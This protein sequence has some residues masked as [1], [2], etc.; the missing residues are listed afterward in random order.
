MY[1]KGADQRRAVRDSLD[2]AGGAEVDQR[3]AA[4]GATQDVRRF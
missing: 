3:E 4:V 1:P 2:G